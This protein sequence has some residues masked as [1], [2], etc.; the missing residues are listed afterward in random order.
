MRHKRWAGHGEINGKFYAFHPGGKYIHPQSAGA[1]GS[2]LANEVRAVFW[3]GREDFARISLRAVVHPT[4]GDYSFMLTHG[5]QTTKYLQPLTCSTTSGARVCLNLQ[6]EGWG[7]ATYPHKTEAVFSTDTVWRAEA[8]TVPRCTR[9]V[10]TPSP[11]H[12]LRHVHSVLC[13]LQVA[14]DVSFDESSAAHMTE[15]TDRIGFTLMF[16]D[17]TRPGWAYADDDGS[18]ILKH[19]TKRMVLIPE[20]GGGPIE[21]VY[22][23]RATCH[24]A[25][26]DMT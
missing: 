9:P 26:H 4:H 21:P 24:I 18:F 20:A 10:P 8:H 2:F 17:Y 23:T 22:M 7:A 5:V 3:E 19:K 16:N 25:Y 6:A 11:V 12:Q 15:A 13:V 14:S 1:G